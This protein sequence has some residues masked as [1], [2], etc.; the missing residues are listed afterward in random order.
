MVILPN[1][2]GMGEKIMSASGYEENL[3]LIDDV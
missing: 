1:S 3:M 2:E